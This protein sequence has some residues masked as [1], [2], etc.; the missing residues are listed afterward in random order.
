MVWE[1]RFDFNFLYSERFFIWDEA[2][3]NVY[4]SPMFHPLIFVASDNSHIG[5]VGMASLPQQA[6]MELVFDQVQQKREIFDVHDGYADVGNWPGLAHDAN[7][8]IVRIEWENDFSD[9]RYPHRG[10]VE[11]GFLPS[12]LQIV[13]LKLC[14]F[15]GEIKTESLPVNLKEFDIR[16]NN[17]SGELCAKSLP[18]QLVRID[19]AVNCLTGTLDLRNLP[20]NL[21][22]LRA[23]QN[24]FSG[25]IQ[26]DSLPRPLRQVN[27]SH[28]QFSGSIQ[29]RGMAKGLVDLCLSHNSFDGEVD[30]E[31]LPDGLQQ[32]ILA[33]CSL[34]GVVDLRKLPSSLVFINVTENN[35]DGSLVIPGTSAHGGDFP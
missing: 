14:F 7:R 24:Y 16:G 21:Q 23:E 2:P 4:L 3:S 18:P 15:E 13:T 20:Q 12:S 5:R 1:V 9:F 31:N 29:F 26:L 22:T 32:L 17:F 35:F 11:L 8:E 34:T 33:G 6:L 25:N 19:V 28:N 10:S 27:L 30:I